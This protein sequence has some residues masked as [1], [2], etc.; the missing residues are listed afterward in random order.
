VIGWVASLIGGF[1]LRVKLIGLGLIT[2]LSAIGY[3]YLRW[4]ISASKAATAEQKAAALQATRDLEQR[5]AQ[6]RAKTRAQQEKLREQI[7]A[8]KERD[9]F[10]R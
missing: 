4:K 3:L 6:S 7:R 8:R 1:S 10:E 2:L 5:I 9:Y